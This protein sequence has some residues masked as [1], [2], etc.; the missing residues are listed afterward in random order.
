MA[1][2]TVEVKKSHT[3][4][5]IVVILIVLGVLIGLVVYY[6]KK[7]TSSNSSFPSPSNNNGSTVTPPSNSSG[8]NSTSTLPKKQTSA[9]A[10][11]VSVLGQ[12]GMAPWGPCPG[13]NDSTANWIWSQDGSDISAQANI[14]VKFQ[15]IYTVPTDQRINLYVIA[16]NTSNVSLNGTNIGPAIGGWGGAGNKIPLDLKAGDNLIEI[17]AINE[18]IGPAGLLASAYDTNPASFHTDSSWVWSAENTSASVSAPP[19]KSCFDLQKNYGIIP[20]I[21]WGSADDQTKDEYSRGS[22]DGVILSNCLLAQRLYGNV[23]G[24]SWGSMEE[25]Y[26]SMWNSKGCD[27]KVVSDCSFAKNTYNYRPGE[28]WGSLPE[29]YRQYVTC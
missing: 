28:T 19:Q 5:I 25:P 1:Q 4:I 8:N 23:P 11:P 2:T 13:F 20:G 3:G 17:V 22:C 18:G 21:T 16:D 7:T 9:N 27:G 29:A 24:I 6:S 15:K 12:V 10:L 26:R 14:K